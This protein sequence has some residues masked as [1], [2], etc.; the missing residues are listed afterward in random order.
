M[1]LRYRCRGGERRGE[2]VDK[3]GGRGGGGR[4]EMGHYIPYEC[5]DYHYV[6][7]MQHREEGPVF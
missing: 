6:V 3:I 5:E 4:V 2:R 7:N 1:K